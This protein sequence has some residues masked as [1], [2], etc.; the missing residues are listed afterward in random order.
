MSNQIIVEQIIS[1][2]LGII[3]A[4]AIYKNKEIYRRKSFYILNLCL[5]GGLFVIPILFVITIII[6][7][8]QYFTNGW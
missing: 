4:I 2:L 1:G 6:V 8:E 3:F 5:S 7:I